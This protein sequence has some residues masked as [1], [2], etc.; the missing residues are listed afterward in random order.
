MTRPE[1][2]T[3]PARAASQVTQ[4][5]DISPPFVDRDRDV[6]FGNAAVR[7]LQKVEVNP[8]TGCWIFT[9][10]L[11]PGGYGQIGMGS[12]RD[13]TRRVRSAHR[14]SYEVFVGPIP[15]GYEL[16]HLCRKRACI[17]PNHLQPVTKAENIR[18]G[19]GG[20]YWA[21]KT[22]CPHGHAYDA[23]NTN[24]YRGRRFCRQ[25]ARDRSASAYR[26][27]QGL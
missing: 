25:C 19:E 17:F 20:A 1:P 26:L 9:G 15:P 10:S 3:K 13:G 14:V 27:K 23:E 2:E 18:R 8:N 6:P 12:A 7:L 4:A 11:T 21:A 16:D 5:G 22:H 24:V